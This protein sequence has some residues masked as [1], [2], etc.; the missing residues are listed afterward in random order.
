MDWNPGLEASAQA[1]G[2]HPSGAVTGK[3]VWLSWWSFYGG[4][5]TCVPEA[6]E[7]GNWKK[8]IK[9]LIANSEASAYKLI[10]RAKSGNWR[11]LARG[12]GSRRNMTRTLCT[13]SPIWSSVT[14]GQI[15][16]VLDIILA[17]EQTSGGNELICKGHNKVVEE[18]KWKTP[19][20]STKSQ[21]FFWI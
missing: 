5:M 10:S 7:Q 11:H 17:E 18:V 8:Q 20:I 13:A 16:P 2:H 15:N 6:Y 19:Y 3:W 1:D 9:K 21:M 4:R 14:S 12:E